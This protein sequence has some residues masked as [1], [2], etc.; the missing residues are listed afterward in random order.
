MF[1]ENNSV[2]VER[3]IEDLNKLRMHNEPVVGCVKKYI[4]NNALIIDLG[5]DIEGVLPLDKFEDSENI[6]LSGIVSKVGSNI[7]AFIEDINESENKVNLNRARLHK[8]YKSEVLDNME[9]GSVFSTNVISVAPFGVF[10]DMGYGVLGLLSKNDISIA[11][12]P[13]INDAFSPD[14]ELKV[15]YKGKTN[16]GYV[17]SHKELLGNWEENVAD[18][19]E[20]EVTLGIIRDIKPYGAFIEIAPNLTGLAD[21]ID[22]FNYKIG[23]SITVLFKSA[24]MDKQK[25]KLHIVKPSPTEYKPKYVYKINSGVLKEWVYTPKSSRKEIKSIFDGS[26]ER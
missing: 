16:M 21:I 11:R 17:V 5:N 7:C 2:F 1:T 13:N 20:G 8:W 26:V 23:Q 24:N 22:G 3:T 6:S 9:Y 4:P 14:E 19:S 18:F 25:V 10:I 15:V 12:I